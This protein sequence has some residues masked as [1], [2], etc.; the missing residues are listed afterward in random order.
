MNG[1]QRV[2]VFSIATPPQDTPKDKRRYRVKW[3]VNGRD[4]TRTFKTRAQADRLRSRL[5]VAANDGELFD[6]ATGLPVSWLDAPPAPT[7]WSWSQEWLML[8]WPQWSG[9]SRRSVVESLVTIT[10]LMV[11]PGAPSPGQELAGW[12]RQC[13]YRPG[14]AGQ[15]D[16]PALLR[17][18]SV[19]LPDIDVQLLERVLHRITTKADGHPMSAEVA[20]RRRNTLGAVLR[21]AVRRG[22]LAT[23]PME[24]IE[25]RTPSRSI[26]VDIGTVPSPR[27][28]EDIVEHVASLCTSG[29]RFAALFATV[30]VA[31][32]RPSEA[33]G[34]RS[35]DLHLPRHGW[36]MAA[37]R[38]A[39]TSP[40]VR[41]TAE[42]TV[43]EA[44][45]LKQ[46]PID[47]VRD[48]PLAP[49][50]VDR[51]RWHLDRWQPVDGRVFSN[52]AGRPMT[53][54]NYGPVWVRARSQLWP[55]GHP[56]TAT[57]VYDLRHS[58]ATMMLRAAVP[59]AEVARRLGHSVD[60]L[61]RVYAG[62]FEDERERS[63]ELIGQALA[64]LGSVAGSEPGAQVASRGPDRLS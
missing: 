26:T 55:A 23:N 29:A 20:R 1:L 28:V 56:L 49:H 9:H 33:M 62:V 60:V 3:R 63:N 46:R 27:D 25:W 40:G 18:W 13:G 45:G 6:L 53:T 42:G 37:L 8:K 38:G 22:L 32:M 24:R 34:L 54:T 61:L 36:G 2:Q 21:S 7:W 59:A 19:P 47:S 31:G 12:L 41:Y 35:Q 64:G 51:L 57:T 5:Q 17:T 44:K 48:V 30:G 10:P 43:V 16:V 50:L 11:R 52:A 14:P 39:V 15:A 58:A 4:K